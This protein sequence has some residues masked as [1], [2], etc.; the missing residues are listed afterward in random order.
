[1]RPF[2]CLVDAAVVREG[3]VVG[4]WVEHLEVGFYLF[5]P[6]KTNG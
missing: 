3:W 2:L 1:M 5:W 4:V 6:M